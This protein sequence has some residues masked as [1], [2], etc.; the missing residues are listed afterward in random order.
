MISGIGSGRSRFDAGFVFSE[1]GAPARARASFQIPAPEGRATTTTAPARYFLAIYS[2]TPWPE[3]PPNSGTALSLET[4]SQINQIGESPAATTTAPAR[5]FLA[6]HCE[7]PRPERPQ[8]SR[9][10]L[11]LETSSQFSQVGGGP[12]TTT[13]VPAR[14]FLTIC[15]ET[16]LTERPKNSRAALSLETSSQFTQVGA[17]PAGSLAWRPWRRGAHTACNAE[18]FSQELAWKETPQKG[19]GS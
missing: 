3:R 6:I 2:E 8:N 11:S 13:R 17:L 14:Y 15:S 9:Q 12:T 19:V 7:T 1:T 18:C 4:S 16:P 5:Y 10:A